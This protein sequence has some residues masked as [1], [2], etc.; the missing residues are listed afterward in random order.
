MISTFADE[1]AFIMSTSCHQ[2]E[3]FQSTS[4]NQI[5][6]SDFGL[7]RPQPN[8]DGG[9][10]DA[11]N[12]IGFVSSKMI[13]QPM[14][15]ANGDANRMISTTMYHSGTSL[16][17]ATTNVSTDTRHNTGNNTA[18]ASPLSTTILSNRNSVLQ[19]FSSG[20]PTSVT[21]STTSTGVYSVS[22]VVNL[23]HNNIHLGSTTRHLPSSS[24]SSSQVGFHPILVAKSAR[25]PGLHFGAEIEAIKKFHIKTGE[26]HE[27]DAEL[28]LKEDQ[29]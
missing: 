12:S 13:W 7:L 19:R 29:H 6:I 17:N 11:L 24:S 22:N 1:S 18:V 26:I 8:L 15:D 23:H 27:N 5:G 21:S 28:L 4:T 20:S 14:G 2:G 3:K 16:G 25:S 9:R 10:P